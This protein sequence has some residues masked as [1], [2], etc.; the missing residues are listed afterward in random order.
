MIPLTVFI[1]EES[2]AADSDY[3]FELVA[4]GDRARAQ[5]TARHDFAIAFYRDAL[6]SEAEPLDQ[7]SQGERLVEFAELS[8]DGDGNHRK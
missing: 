4:M 8:V 7:L 1:R 5:L 2:A 3:D 6:A